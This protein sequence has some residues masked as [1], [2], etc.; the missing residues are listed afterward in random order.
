MIPGALVL[1]EYEAARI[2]QSWDPTNKI[3][4]RKEISLLESHQQLT[5]RQL[6][7]ISYRAIKAKNWVGVIGLGT[8]CIE[9]IPKIDEQSELKTSALSC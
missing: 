8:R 7:D 1:R 3:V 6:F 2:G 5:S 9:V 4:S